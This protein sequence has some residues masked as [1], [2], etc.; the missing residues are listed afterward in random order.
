MRKIA[1][2]RYDLQLQKM[3]GKSGG[4]ILVV[5]KSIAKGTAVGKRNRCEGT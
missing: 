4:N 2:R 3:I 5:G 1:R